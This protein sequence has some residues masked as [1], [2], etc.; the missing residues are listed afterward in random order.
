MD[1]DGFEFFVKILVVGKYN[2]EIFDFISE[3]TL[4]IRF[5]V[6]K[7]YKFLESYAIKCKFLE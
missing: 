5:K 1:S 6:Q 2:F 3:S 7:S 4:F